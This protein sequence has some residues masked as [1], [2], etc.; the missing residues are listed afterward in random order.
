MRIQDEVHPLD[1]DDASTV[2]LM[3][4]GL[5]TAKLVTGRTSV[6]DVVIVAI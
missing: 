6:T 1:L 5:E 4:I 2:V 3:A